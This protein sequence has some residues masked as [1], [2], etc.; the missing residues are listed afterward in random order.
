MQVMVSDRKKAMN[1]LDGEIE[2]VPNFADVVLLESDEPGFYFENKVDEKGLRWASL[3]QTW[4]EL[5]NGDARQQD[6]A[7]EAE[8]EIRNLIIAPSYP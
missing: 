7:R 3:L 4:I 8:R 5:K 1:L 2:S 6:A